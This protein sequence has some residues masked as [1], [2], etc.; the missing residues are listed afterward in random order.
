MKNAALQAALAKHDG[1]LP[2]Q[3]V[4]TGSDSD[5]IRYVTVKVEEGSVSVGSGQAKK[6][7]FIEGRPA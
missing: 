3:F 1:A 6:M 4:D 5:T 2:V 7:L